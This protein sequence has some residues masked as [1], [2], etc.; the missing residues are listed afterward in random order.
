[1]NPDPIHEN[2]ERELCDWLLEKAGWLLVS[3]ATAR[4]A[5]LA[6]MAAKKLNNETKGT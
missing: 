5:A 4:D 3:K 6:A 1:M 2:D